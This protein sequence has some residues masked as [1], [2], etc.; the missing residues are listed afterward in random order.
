MSVRTIVGFVADFSTEPIGND[1]SGKELA[2]FVAQRL[3]DAGFAVEA[4]NNREDWAWDFY[5]KDD[6]LKIQTIV[7][8]VDDMDSDPPRQWLITNDCC[9]LGF[10]QRLFGTNHLAEKRKQMLRRICEALHQIISADS[11]FSHIVWYDEDTF[12]NPDDQPGASP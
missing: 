7:G 9:E 10:F 4:P 5:T 6:E 11:R 3:K 8:L 1:P 2:A 12:D